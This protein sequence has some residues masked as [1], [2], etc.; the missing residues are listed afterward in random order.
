MANLGHKSVLLNESLDF[1]NI[2]KGETYIDATFGSGGHTKKILEAG[3]KVLAIDIDPEAVKRGSQNFS[4]D[5]QDKEGIL[6]GER[7]NLILTQGNF[8]DLESIAGKFGVWEASGV[9]F[10]LGFS[11]IQLEEGGKG[12]SFQKDEP[13]DMRL[14]PRLGVSAADLINGLS[15]KELYELFSRYGEESNSRYIARAVVSARAKKRIET[16]KQLAEIIISCA[17]RKSKVHPAT[18]VFLALRIVVNDEPGNLEKGLESA[19]RLL[20]KHGRIVVISFH[21]LE[22]RIVKNFFNKSTNLKVLTKKPIS[23]TKEEILDNP[24]SRSARLRLAERI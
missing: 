4:I 19:V 3:G 18:R 7:E 6:F 1:L 20:R 13:L 9:L 23:P 15:Q 17:K 21:S 12:L 10:D 24:R 5:L 2:K 22:D 11:S 16:S 14:D 8:A